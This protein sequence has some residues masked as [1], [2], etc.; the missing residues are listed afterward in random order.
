MADEGKFKNYIC[1]TTSEQQKENLKKMIKDKNIIVL[2]HEDH[3]GFG[4][5]VYPKT[6]CPLS[7]WKVF[8]WKAMD[9]KIY[10]Y[11]LN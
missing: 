1:I 8:D 11:M 3:Y 4:R 9:K 6:R 5:N 10:D 7:K 2:D